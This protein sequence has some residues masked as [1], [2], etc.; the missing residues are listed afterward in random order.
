MCYYLG[1][2]QQQDADDVTDCQYNIQPPPKRCQRHTYMTPRE[3]GL[4]GHPK[5]RRIGSFRDR[6][7]F[8]DMVIVKLE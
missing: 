1:Y 5:K 2:Q 3:D 4:S 6:P 8:H 7:A